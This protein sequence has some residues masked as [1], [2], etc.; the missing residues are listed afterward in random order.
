MPSNNSAIS[1]KQH[2]FDV[3]EQISQILENLR[4]GS[5]T[6]VVHDGKVVEI[7]RKEKFRP[8]LNNAH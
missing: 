8:N 6:I 3:Q 2:S 5:I 4:F 7:E 1:R